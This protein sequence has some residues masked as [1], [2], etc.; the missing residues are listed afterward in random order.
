M[1]TFIARVLGDGVNDAPQALVDEAR[2]GYWKRYGATL[3]GLIK[4]HKVSA[5]DFLHQTHD[6]GDLRAMNTF[7]FALMVGKIACEASCKVLSR[8]NS[9]S[10]EDLV[11]FGT[12][13]S[14]RKLI[15]E[16]ACDVRL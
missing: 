1:N 6:L 5:A 8:S 9:H 10:G 2:I 7:M 15:K 14:S 11:I 3:L 4:H 16:I 13:S 12:G